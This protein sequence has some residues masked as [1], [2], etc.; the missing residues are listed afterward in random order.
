MKIEAIRS[1][2]TKCGSHEF[3]W[4]HRT[5][6]MGIINVTPDSFSGDGLAGYVEDAITTARLMV[7]HGADII[8][9]GG[10]STRPASVYP[11]AKPVSVD[12][13][14][15]RVLPVIIGLAKD[16]HVPVGIDTYKAEV[17]RQA[18]DAGASI[19]NDVWGG[20]RDPEMAPL[21]AQRDVPFIIM[22][23]Q[24]TTTYA[25]L[26]PDMIKAL[27]ALAESALAAG[28][29]K[30]NIIIDPGIGFGKSWE[31]NIVIMQRLSEFKTLGFP[32]LV[33]TSRKSFIGRVLE[34]PVDDRLEGTS[35]T[36]ALS[37]AGAA[38]IVRVHDVKAMVRVARMTDA[39]V[40]GSITPIPAADVS[41]DA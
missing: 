17:A 19:V 9:V 27:A 34:L 18:L 37:I 36:V 13:E 40:R 35:A 11:D 20:S 5:Y 10:E 25:D 39:I 2:T 22:H 30:E 16:V 38:D 31:Q 21:V 4:G 6:V 12:E 14:L 7:A 41:H 26:I 8:D 29:K 33:G 32:I 15:A 23:N 1:H 24:E 3:K 28:V